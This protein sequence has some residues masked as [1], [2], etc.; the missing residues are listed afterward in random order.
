M[1]VWGTPVIAIPLDG[2]GVTVDMH[3]ENTQSE[4]STSQAIPFSVCSSMDGQ[5]QEKSDEQV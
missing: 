4:S 1:S 5:L 2:V 3:T